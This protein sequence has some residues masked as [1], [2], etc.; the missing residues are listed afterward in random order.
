M[1]VILCLFWRY[2]LNYSFWLF[3]LIVSGFDCFK[4]ILMVLM[5]TEFT[6]GILARVKMFY[7]ENEQ[8]SRRV[9]IMQKFWGEI[10]YMSTLLAITLD[11]NFALMQGLQ[12]WKLKFKSFL[13]VYYIPNSDKRARNYDRL[14]FA[15]I[16]GTKR[17]KNLMCKFYLTASARCTCRCRSN[18]RKLGQETC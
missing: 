15:E 3:M 17:R 9:F 13:T 10:W 6:K 12:H 14:K 8:K 5:M 7:K 1:L 11:S 2:M 4:H 18:T 16:V